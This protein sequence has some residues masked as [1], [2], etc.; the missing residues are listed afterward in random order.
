MSCS[1]LSVNPT[2]NKILADELEQ[3]VMVCRVKTSRGCRA[4][5][6]DALAKKWIISPEIARQMLLQT[7]HCVFWT[8]SE[9]SLSRWFSTNDRQMHYKRLSHNIFTD[10]LEA[11]ELSRQ[12]ERHAQVFS[13]SNRWIQ[14]FPM[15]KKS[16]AHEAL[17]LLFH[18]DGVLPKMIM[19]GLKEQTKG[20]FRKK[21]LLANVHI[22]QT[23]PYSPWKNYSESAI[24][25]LKKGSGRKMV[26]ARASN[27]YG[28]I[29]LSLK[30][31]FSQTQHGIYISYKVRL[32]RRSCL[33]RRLISVSFA[34]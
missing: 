28:Q 18:W 32:H 21:C 34:N 6:T 9:S 31:M 17:D 7:S 26:R 27:C 11:S 4:I 12:Q 16:D 22:K 29:V 25:E 2:N 13:A 8:M 24:L 30:L 10:T 1:H 14:A 20:Q 5:D 33:V 19:D 3:N 23:E 15:K